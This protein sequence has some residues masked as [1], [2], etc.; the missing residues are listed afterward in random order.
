[1]TARAGDTYLLLDRSLQALIDHM[2]RPLKH[3]IQTSWP[4]HSIN[5]SQDGATLHGPNGR[6]K[7][8]RKVLVTASLAVLQ[9]GGIAFQPQMPQAKRAAL[10]RLKMSNAIKVGCGGDLPLTRFQQPCM[11]MLE[12]QCYASLMPCFAAGAGQFALQQVIT[13]QMC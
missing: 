12:W 10:G 8:C 7:D 9:R 11:T 1:M 13:E 5:Y 4:V 2:A 3:C 6:R